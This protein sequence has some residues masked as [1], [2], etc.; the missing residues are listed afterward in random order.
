M[1]EGFEGPRYVYRC[2]ETK[3]ESEMEEGIE[4]KR[5]EEIY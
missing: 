2:K 1:I 5:R 3:E 4:E